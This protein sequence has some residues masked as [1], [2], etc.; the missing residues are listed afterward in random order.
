MSKCPASDFSLVAAPSFPRPSSAVAKHRLKRRLLAQPSLGISG[1]VLLQTR[2][3][4][5]HVTAYPKIL[6]VA[7]TA[8]IDACLTT[9]DTTS[10]LKSVTTSQTSDNG[11][12]KGNISQI[13]AAHM[14]SRPETGQ[15]QQALKLTVLP[16]V[17]TPASA[18]EILIKGQVDFLYLMPDPTN[19]Y[20]LCIVPNYIDTV[21]IHGDSD[22]ITMSKGGIMRQDKNGGELTHFT[23][24][25]YLNEYRVYTRLRK[26]S[27]FKNFRLW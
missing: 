3:P 16:T 18:V 15:Q 2:T 4:P 6:S 1:N 9:S 5:L 17:Y 22:V 12:G 7:N 23:L 24:N 11:N 21:D 19:S 20:K 25:E 27:V 13:A 26:I 10:V 14:S 8:H